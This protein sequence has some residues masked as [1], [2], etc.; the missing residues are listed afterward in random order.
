MDQTQI[1][2]SAATNQGSVL[3]N[4]QFSF[5]FVSSFSL[6]AQF[7]VDITESVFCGS[8]VAQCYVLVYEAENSNTRTGETRQYKCLIYISFIE[9]TREQFFF[10]CWEE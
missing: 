8:S 1:G 3:A 4:Y 10:S 5:V 7:V 2:T 6:G 9:G